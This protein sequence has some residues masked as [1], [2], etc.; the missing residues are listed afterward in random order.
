MREELVK[1]A[2]DFLENKKV[3][4]SSE[5]QQKNFLLGKGLTEEEVQEA[6]DRVKAK[7]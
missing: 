7:H 3:V 4:G 2:M 1:K 6:L 5:K